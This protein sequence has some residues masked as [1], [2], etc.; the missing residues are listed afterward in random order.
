MRAFP[1]GAG[2][3]VQLDQPYL[4]FVMMFKEPD[5]AG[6]HGADHESKNQGV[7]LDHAVK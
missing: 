1:D 5:S 4:E 7:D 3:R 2:A 6:L